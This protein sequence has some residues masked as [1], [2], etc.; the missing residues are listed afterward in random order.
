[1]DSRTRVPSW[2]GER[3]LT[4]YLQASP[5]YDRREDG[6][7]VNGGWAKSAPMDIALLELLGDEDKEHSGAQLVEELVDRGWSRESAE[8]AFAVSPAI[9][10]PRRG[11]YTRIGAT[12]QS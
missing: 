1:M 6:W 3:S 7:V 12:T 8:H 4:A 10:A 2:S 9:R 5:L 11:V